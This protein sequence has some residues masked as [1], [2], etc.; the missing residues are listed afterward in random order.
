MEEE[1]S[2]G[3]EWKAKEGEEDLT[4]EQYNFLNFNI[5]DETDNTIVRISYKLYPKFK[6][7]MW[8]LPPGSFIAVRGMVTGTMRMV[9]AYSIINLYDLRQAYIDKKPLDKLQKAFVEN[10]REKKNWRRRS[11]GQFAP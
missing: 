8:A 6:A 9:F 10:S 7:M 2:R 1:A 3:N 11:E 5:E 4:R